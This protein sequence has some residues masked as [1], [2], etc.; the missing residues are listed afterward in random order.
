MVTFGEA[1]GEILHFMASAIAETTL[2]ACFAAL[3]C[4]T[5]GRRNQIWGIRCSERNQ[6]GSGDV[7]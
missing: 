6:P 4:R 5:R 7:R 3:F 1:A 2:V